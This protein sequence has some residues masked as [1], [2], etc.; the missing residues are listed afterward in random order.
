MRP[1]ASWSG[2][3][4]DTHQYY[5]AASDL[6]FITSTKYNPVYQLKLNLHLLRFVV[7]LLNNNQK[8]I[9]QVEHE[10]YTFASFRFYFAH[11]F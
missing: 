1:K 9:E 3:I 2:L 8:H 7:N 6:Q 11:R 4:C 10:L 5:T